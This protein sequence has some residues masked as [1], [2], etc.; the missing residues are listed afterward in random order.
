MVYML[1]CLD[2]A[3]EVDLLGGLSVLQVPSDPIN[4]DLFCCTIADV[5]RLIETK[6][7]EMEENS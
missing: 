2:K 6:L 7:V 4:D 5:V 1:E 3:L